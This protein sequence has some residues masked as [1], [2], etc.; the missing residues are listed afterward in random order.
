VVE[1]I[2]LYGELHRFIPVLASWEGFAVVEMPVRHFKRKYGRSK[3]GARRFLNGFFDLITV[4]FVTRRS[5]N[6]L[7]F[8]GRIAIVLFT[9]GVTPQV[10]FLIHWMMGSALR[11]RPIMLLGFVLIIVALQ[12]GSIGL[13]A[14]MVSA[15]SARESNY[16]FKEYSLAEGD[17]GDAPAP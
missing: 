3:F 2:T 12:I 14:E 9:L 1:S 16:S 17:A 15:R 11:V 7:H 5:L 13:L 10:W 8:F 4:M 6:P